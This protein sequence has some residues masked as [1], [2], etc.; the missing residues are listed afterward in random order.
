MIGVFKLATLF[1]A[2]AIV[3]LA[4]QTQ[5]DAKTLTLNQY[6]LPKHTVVE[7]GSNQ[8]IE[9]ISEGTNGDL[10]IRLFTGGTPL[11]SAATFGG[12]QSGIVDFG[13]VI[14]TYHPA[15]LPLQQFLNDI[16]VPTANTRVVAAAFN[17]YVLQH[18]E[19]C[20]A[21]FS[22]HG[23]VFTGSYT[24]A[25]LMLIT[26]ERYTSAADL[27]GKKIRIP[28]GDYNARWAAHFKL[29]PVN[30]GGSEIYEMM[31]RG[32]VDV[33]LNPASVLRSHSLADVAKG[34]ITLPVTMHRVST[35]YM[36][37]KESWVALTPEQRRLFLDLLPMAI[38][39]ITDAY[40]KDAME[41]VEGA[42][43]KGILVT[44]P[45]DDLLE[46]MEKFTKADLEVLFEIAQERYNVE[47]PEK[48]YNDFLA[49]IAK[50]EGIAE[51]V[52]N[53]PVKLGERLR[54]DVYAKLD[55]NS[56]GN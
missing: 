36:A 56:F 41:V 50:W 30:V 45:G 10:E 17:E 46:E 32:A 18:C 25:P 34:I 2:T 38:M 11:S 27:V 31:N 12:L 47:D 51:S 24:A 21:E 26:R 13:M 22:T 52:D 3:A 5:A 48:V 23:V 54:D 49:L 7:H 9:E 8:L 42:A 40:I 4:A 37:R 16:P 1:S 53:D 33:E 15:E 20:L 39:R 44:E 28:G 19:P 35:P 14:N 6:V 29:S 55:E 43:E